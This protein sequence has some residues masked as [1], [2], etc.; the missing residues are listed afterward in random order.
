MREKL[1][2]FL[3]SLLER[4][5]VFAAFTQ[6]EKWFVLIF[7]RNISINI[8]YFVFAKDFLLLSLLGVITYEKV[9]LGAQANLSSKIDV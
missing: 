8:L 7:C 4:K 5:L 2:K 1:I 9:K 3:S 6:A